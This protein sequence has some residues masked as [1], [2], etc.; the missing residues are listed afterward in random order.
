LGFILGLRSSF[1]FVWLLLWLWERFFIMEVD[2][3]LLVVYLKAKKPLK[4][5]QMTNCLDSIMLI[6]D[7]LT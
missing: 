5:P 4:S 7:V 3:T 2:R 6:V 1:G